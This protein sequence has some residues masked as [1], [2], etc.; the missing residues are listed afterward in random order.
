[1][2]DYTIHIE[3]VDYSNLR[4]NCEY[5]LAME[6]SDL[7]SFYMKNYRFHPKVKAHIWDGKIRL[8]NSGKRLLPIGLLKQLIT[9]CKND[10]IEYTI[11]DEVKE[12]LKGNNE[13]TKDIVNSYN[14]PFS[15]YEH[16]SIAIDF[17]INKK[18]GLVLSPTSS[19]KSLNI[20]ALARYNTEN[21]TRTLIIVPT[22]Q[23]VNQ[24]FDDFKDYGWDSEKY[25]HKIYSGQEKETSNP[26]V[27]STWQSLAKIP[28]SYLNDFD[29]VI[30]DE[31]HL[32]TAT[33][34]KT[35][36]EK[37]TKVGSKIGLTGTLDESK[38]NKET[39]IAL[40]GDVIQATTT[41]ELMEK[42]LV[43]E[44]KIKCVQ[45]SYPEEISKVVSKMDYVSETK[46]LKT[47]EPRNEFIVNLSTKTKGNTLVLFQ[48]LS[49][50]KELYE[51]IKEKRKNVFYIDG[52]TDADLRSVYTEMFEKYDDVILVASYG[53]FSTGIN[54]KNLHNI[55]FSSSY[56]S[57][58]K[59]LQSL[60]RSLRLHSRKDGATLYDLGDNHRYKKYTNTI[61]KHF[62]ERIK[63]YEKEQFNYKIVKVNLK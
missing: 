10:G 58:V 27:I 33:T 53:V 15:P 5:G 59:V 4:V 62:I 12:K 61:F 24:L 56:K 38:A 11:D 44:L 23:L 50:G 47:Y 22:V 7:F 2:D 6:F 51:K 3:W 63:L 18:R 1:M 9:Y 32:A 35:I 54:S 41:K 8:F 37:C 26:V 21:N 28:Q 30:V 60:G 39:L 57:K 16:Q 31:V 14:L 19:G 48:H 43:S 40:F 34:L 29:C 49:H 20:Y 42:G 45:L 55:I 13:N 36:M 52:K 46:F 17:M 25:V